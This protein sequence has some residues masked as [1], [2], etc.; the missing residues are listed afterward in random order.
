MPAI[1]EMSEFGRTSFTVWLSTMVIA[2]SRAT[3][4]SSSTSAPM[5][6]AIELPSTFFS[7][8]RVRL[9]TTSSAVKSS[10]FDHL[11]PL[12]TFKV[13]SVALSLISQLSSS[14]GVK[15]ES[16]SQRTRYS[17]DWRET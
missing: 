7:H 11:M 3:P 16:V 10:P 4:A 8:Q 17:Q 9:N 12:R 5:R 1:S 15:V 13:Y 2:P 6:A 14:Q